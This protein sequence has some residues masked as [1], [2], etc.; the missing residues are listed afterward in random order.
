MNPTV[1]D[2]RSVGRDEIERAFNE[3]DL[4]RGRRY[5]KEGYVKE[6]VKK[7]GKLFGLVLGSRP[8][9]YRVEVDLSQG[10][11]SECTCPV[12]KMCKHGVA[13]LL[14]WIN[15]E[16]W[17]ID[18]DQLLISLRSRTKEELIDIIATMVREK[19]CQVARTL[20][21]R[22]RGAQVNKEAIIKRID[23]ATRGFIDWQ[24]A[25]AVANEFEEV[26]GIADNLLDEGY[27]MDAI[28][29]YLLLIEKGVE[30]FEQGADDS[31]GDIGW[32]LT[33][34]VR[35]CSQ[36]IEKLDEE[37]R[38]RLIPRIFHIV[39]IE[40]YGLETKKLITAVATRENKSIITEKI[41]AR[42]PRSVENYH[43]KYK[44]D[45][46]LNILVDV[47]ENL[48]LLEDVPK[49]L[50]EVRLENKSDYLRLAK[51]LKNQGEEKRAFK[52]IKEGVKLQ[53]KDLQ[54]DKLYFRVLSSLLER[55]LEMEEEFE[56]NRAT[57]IALRLLDTGNVSKN[58]ELAKKVFKKAGRYEELFS[59]VREECD[60]NTLLTLLL[61]EEN[62]GEVIELA[63]TKPREL[64]RYNLVNAADVAKDKGRRGAVKKIM[65]SWLEK[66]SKASRDLGGS[67]EIKS[68]LRILVEE[69]DEEQLREATGYIKFPSLTKKFARLLINRN[70]ALA[71]KLLK[72]IITDLKAEAVKNY[73]NE[74]DNEFAVDLLCHWVHKFINRS[75]VYYDDAIKL[76]RIIR[77]KMGEE[78]NEYISSFVERNSGKKKLLEK[79]R[80]SGI[81]G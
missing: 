61:H 47:Y 15:N 76:L 70:Q 6:G 62:Y 10:I 56:S 31:G 59:T 23:Y 12:G 54:L 55:E 41:L 18:A 77:K 69:S 24:K 2:V 53:G 57:N 22:E 32:V 26:S 49:L 43:A 27:I 7:G 34:I 33:K 17:F 38:E 4:S 60:T 30:T 50:E 3:K 19:P 11:Y 40:D 48:G 67:S 28:D 74:M 46:F 80:A 16:E 14:K 20:E 72:G 64:T 58:Y 35:R 29:L 39:E 25:R 78:W 5:Y 63:L 42:T 71:V 81:V 8:E 9:P 13:L 21:D 79:L 45:E 36:A 68:L 1:R 51:I 73:A 65:F 52:V 66:R 37:E 75:Y 44:R